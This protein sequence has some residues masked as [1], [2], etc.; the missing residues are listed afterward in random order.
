MQVCIL[1]SPIME[2]DMDLIRHLLLFVAN[3]PRFDGLSMLSPE[4]P[5]DFG[6]DHYSLDQVTYHIGLLIEAGFLKGAV[7]PVVPYVSRLTWQGHEFLDDIRDQTIWVKTKERIHGLSSVA[8]SVVSEIAK[9]EI[10][11]KLGLA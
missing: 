4:I 7:G 3:D 8:L 6:V 2:R 10:K 9:A 1:R 11:K 5:S